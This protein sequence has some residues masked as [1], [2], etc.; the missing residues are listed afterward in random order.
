MDKRKRT[1][2]KTVTMISKTVHRK[3]KKKQHESN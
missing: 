2:I 3:Q 1:N